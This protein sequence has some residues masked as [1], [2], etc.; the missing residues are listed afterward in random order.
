M[1]EGGA[2]RIE[3]WAG[4]HQRQKILGRGRVGVIERHG[5]DDDRRALRLH[6]AHQSGQRR[7]WPWPGSKTRGAG[8]IDIDDAHCITGLRARVFVRARARHLV[9]IEQNAAQP[10]RDAA[11]IRTQHEQRQAQH[12]KWQRPNDERPFAKAH[13][14][15]PTRRSAADMKNLTRKKRAKV[16]LCYGIVA[17]TTTPSNLACFCKHLTNPRRAGGEGEKRARRQHDAGAGWGVC[18]IGRNQAKRGR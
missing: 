18:A 6:I 14:D 5:K 10:C 12:D 3:G 1:F 9:G 16:N 7:V 17:A 4:W 2:R 15:S 13:G 11:R 8:G